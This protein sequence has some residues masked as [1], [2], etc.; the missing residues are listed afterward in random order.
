MFF[1]VYLRLHKAYNRLAKK[2]RPMG[3]NFYHVTTSKVTKKYSDMTG[4]IIMF[5]P[6]RMRLKN[7]D[8]T[9]KQEELEMNDVAGLS[10]NMKIRVAFMFV[11]FLLNGQGI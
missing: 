11:L 1:K 5:R 4:K 2:Y 10:K 3:I 8:V 9:E 7:E 6:E